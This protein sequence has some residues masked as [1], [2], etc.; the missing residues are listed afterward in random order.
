[1]ASL[2]KRYQE[3]FQDRRDDGPTAST[4]QAAAELPPTANAPKP[5]EPL[6]IETNAADQAALRSRIAEIERAEELAR[7]SVPQQQRP[8]PETQQTAPAHVQA[9]VNAHP[10]YVN[11]PVGQAE[12][13][14]AATKTHREGL[15]WSH[16]NFLEAIERHL[17]LRQANG[18]TPNHQATPTPAA[19][20]RPRPPQLSP[21]VSAPPTRDT[22]S[23]TTGRPQG[24]PM[25]LSEEQRQLARTL[26]ISDEEYR[27]GLLRMNREKAGGLH[28]SNG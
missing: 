2:R 6:Q 9:W 3:R 23:W 24:T 20:P 15:D 17:G 27:Q 4:P 7:Q 18:S 1:V 12:L 26:G 19:P 16:P 22:P 25:Q 5:A 13:Q 8:Q 14:L 11:D 21:P 10:R 28:N